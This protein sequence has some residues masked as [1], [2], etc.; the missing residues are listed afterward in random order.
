MEKGAPNNR[1]RKAPPDGDPALL[2]DPT[3]LLVVGE[4]ALSK[5]LKFLHPLDM[6]KL[7]VCCKS[8]RR[9]VTPVLD[10]LTQDMTNNCD[11]LSDA[12]GGRIQLI[13]YVNAMELMKRVRP[14]IRLHQRPRDWKQPEPIQSERCRGCNAFPQ[15]IDKEVFYTDGSGHEFF[16]C[17]FDERNGKIKFSGFVPMLGEVSELTSSRNSKL[18]YDFRPRSRDL[19]KGA[20][21]VSILSAS[22]WT[23][24]RDL[25]SSKLG[26]ESSFKVDN[27]E[28]CWLAW[29][30]LT[31]PKLS[32]IA[33]AVEKETN[34]ASLLAAMSD[35][36]DNKN[37]YGSNDVCAFPRWTT[38]C[39]I[40]SETSDATLGA[41][42]TFD[43]Y[44][45]FRWGQRPIINF[46][47]LFF[48]DRNHYG[49]L[50]RGDPDDPENDMWDGMWM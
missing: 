7:A 25:L 3:C 35:F 27:K 2:P 41:F 50:L 30:L 20:D 28:R 19:S 24:M 40:H 14:I 38:C 4:D 21:L 31:Q 5:V 11:R 22:G 26:S 17:F 45:R 36:S 48:G 13:R 37:L 29:D 49:P 33:M 43:L 8:L 1:K 39:E 47:I 6:C 44:C 23:E 42:S 32:C 9:L 15:M 18:C 34:N 12:E 16:L 10:D 46:S